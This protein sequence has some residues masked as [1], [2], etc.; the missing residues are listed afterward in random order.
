MSIHIGSTDADGSSTLGPGE[1][2]S[3]AISSA[4]GGIHEGHLGHAGIVFLVEVSNVGGRWVAH[5]H[6]IVEDFV[7]EEQDLDEE[8]KKAEYMRMHELMVQFYQDKHQLV[9]AANNYRSWEQEVSD[10]N[11]LFEMLMLQQDYKDYF[12][13][14]RL[15]A[16][17]AL[18]EGI[19]RSKRLAA[20]EEE[21]P[22]LEAA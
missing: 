16:Q 9:A 17:K 15:R 3:R 2:V 5:V 22:A 21:R 11:Y 13:E 1:A 4:M 19:R 7:L 12:A 18:E 14:E 8:H 6:A 10:E 20:E